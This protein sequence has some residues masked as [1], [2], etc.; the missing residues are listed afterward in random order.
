MKDNNGKLLFAV[1]AGAAAGFALGMFLAPKKGSDLR[2]DV[3]DSLDDLGEK[4]SQA[5]AEG[6]EKL[7]E[8]SGLSG[9]SE[10]DGA[11]SSMSGSGK[12]GG[13]ASGYPKGHNSSGAGGKQGLS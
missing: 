3:M 10:N 6:R 2:Q 7:M 12:S 8:F 4:V 5:V 13:G 9:D 1:L 11:V